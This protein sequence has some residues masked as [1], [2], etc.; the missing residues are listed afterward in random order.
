VDKLTAIFFVC[1]LVMGCA[2]FS[3]MQRMDAFDE[4]V[5]EYSRALEWSDFDLASSFMRTD[6]EDALAA[7]LENLKTIQITGY[8][9]K[10]FRVLEEQ[11]RIE[12]VVD[13]SYFKRDAM[14]VM[15][16]R[17]VQ[18]WEYDQEQDRWQLTTGF[19]EFK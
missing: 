10:K 4:T 8:E 11:R 19:P 13:L 18:L 9:V 5:K 6:D 17:D 12:Q 16:T 14:V 3:D 1:L 15:R 7:S 2:S